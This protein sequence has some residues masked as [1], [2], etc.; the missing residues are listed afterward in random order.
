VGVL[1]VPYP[2]LAWAVADLYFVPA[3]PT[4]AYGHTHRVVLVFTAY[5]AFFYSIGAAP[6]N[7]DTCLGITA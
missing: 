7:S 1:L 5:P 3:Q 2:P 4:P 6:L